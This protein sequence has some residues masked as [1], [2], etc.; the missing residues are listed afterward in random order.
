MIWAWPKTI[1]IVLDEFQKSGGWKSWQQPVGS[2]R[3]DL[4]LSKNHVCWRR[5]VR[6][7][8]QLLGSFLIR[9]FSNVVKLFYY[10]HMIFLDDCWVPLIASWNKTT[11]IGMSLPCFKFFVFC[12]IFKKPIKTQISSRFL[13]PSMFWFL[14]NISNTKHIPFNSHLSKLYSLFF[15]QSHLR[16]AVKKSVFFRNNS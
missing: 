14:F 5:E 11:F 4:G 2:D 13:W 7:H 12:F 16:E 1:V 3:N 8:H 10:H 6:S 9:Q 15:C